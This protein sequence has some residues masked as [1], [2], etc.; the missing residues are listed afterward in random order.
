MKS[1]SV[2]KLPENALGFK[3]KYSY[4]VFF[5]YD[6]ECIGTH[7]CSSYEIADWRGMRY[8]EALEETA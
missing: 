1:Y 3:Q 8:I 4:L 2:I 6:C 5:Y 7:T